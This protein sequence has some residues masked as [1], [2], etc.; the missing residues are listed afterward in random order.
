[1]KAVVSRSMLIVSI[2][3]S[4]HER[5]IKTDQ[6]VLAILSE[7]KTKNIYPVEQMSKTGGTEPPRRDLDHPKWN[8]P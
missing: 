4:D 8:L 3:D 6:N 1:M 5:L 2:E 7:V